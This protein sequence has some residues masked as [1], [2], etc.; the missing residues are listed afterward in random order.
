[1]RITRTSVTLLAAI[2]AL[3]IGAV[4]AA[5]ASAAELEQTPTS[6]KFTVSAAGG[7]FQTKSG[8]EITCKTVSGSG[9]VTGAKTAT[10]KVTFEG[11]TS[12]GVKCTAGKTSGSIETE[13]NGELVWLS[14]AGLSAGQ[15]LTLAKE[16]T[17]TCLFIKIKV[18]GS[19]LCPIEPVNEKTTTLKLTCK[20]KGGK[21]EFT[22]YENEEGKKIQ[23][24]TLTNISGTFEESGLASTESLSFSSM[25]EV[26][27]V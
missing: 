17:V 3:A 10:S 22:E 24:I 12:S 23:A 7:T 11:C 15:K 8:S 6:G 26:K 9:E 21:Q 19:T 13:I 25:V 16:L 2:V 14:K 27:V 1:M 4:T 18:K 20:Q 5:S